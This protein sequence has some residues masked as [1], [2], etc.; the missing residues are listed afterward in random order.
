MISTCT[1]WTYLVLGTTDPLYRYAVWQFCKALNHYW[2][3]LSEPIPR[4][5]DTH[6]LR[7]QHAV[8]KAVEALPVNRRQE[9][10]RDQAQN[11]TGREVMFMNTMSELEVLI[12]HSPQ[13]ERD[14]LRGLVAPSFGFSERKS[15]L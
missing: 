13:R 7:W 12:E 10:T 5:K 11:N 9:L 6:T 2:S 8:L 1:N 4:F 14:R 15:L 3:L